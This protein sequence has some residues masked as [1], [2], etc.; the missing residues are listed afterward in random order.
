MHDVEITVAGRAALGI[1]EV[2]L[3]GSRDAQARVVT[4]LRDRF[5]EGEGAAVIRQGAA[6]LRQQV[7][8][9]GPA[10]N[11]LPLMKRVKEQF[12]PSMLLNP[13]RGP[14]GI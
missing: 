3:N 4:K 5:S 10:S 2:W 11:A 9:W 1:M 7:N 6:S 14:W 12:D 8:P 13:G